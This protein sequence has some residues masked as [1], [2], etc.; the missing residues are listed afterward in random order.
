MTIDSGRGSEGRT[1]VDALPAPVFVVQRQRFV[2]VNRAFEALM[3][4]DRTALVGHDSLERVHPDDR[5][6][7]PQAAREGGSHNPSPTQIRVKHGDGAER[8]LLVTA[9]AATY[10]GAPALLGTAVDATLQPDVLNVS[11]R[12]AA[13]GRLAGGVAHD[14]NN[15]LLVVGG[16]IE[17]LR[18]DWPAESDVR[19]GLDTIT[20][21]AERAGMLTDQ[22]LSFG[23]RQML[24]PQVLDA[25]GFLADVEPQLQ[26]RLGPSIQLVVERTADVPSIRADRPRLREVLW[27]LADNA[28]DAMPAGGVLTVTVDRVTIDANLKARWAFLQ[29][30][31]EFVR[32]RVIDTGAGMNPEVMPHVFEPFF[33]TKGRGRGAGMG[34]ASVY[35]IVKQSAGYVFVERTGVEGTCVT[36]LLP[37]ADAPPD[38]AGPVRE[39]ESPRSVGHPPR[40]L[41]VEDDMAVR[42]MLADMLL[43]HGFDVA[44]A[45]TAEQAQLLASEASFDVLLSDIDLP[46]MSGA[47]LAAALSGRLPD[48]Q[49]ILMSAIPTMARLRRRDWRERRRCSGSRF[50]RRP[51]WTGSGNWSAQ[52]NPAI[53]VAVSHRPS[54]NSPGHQ[55]S[56]RPPPK[57]D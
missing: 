12:L 37:A 14:F 24:T 41:L 26:A 18:H 25:S 17:R 46:G 23:R 50:Q 48:L 52:P 45:E 43:A 22:L 35:G 13:L 21:A 7:A 4:L 34:L 27:H 29:L 47:R 53:H 15:L 39:A 6:I 42:E 31:V 1:L 49:I 8:S 16:Q 32:L 33:T 38:A 9:V 10:D 44:S 57:P 5:G 55:P 11:V 28:R 19:R 36:I 40:I 51:S 30:G 2:Y 54:A 3:G 56:A 20:V